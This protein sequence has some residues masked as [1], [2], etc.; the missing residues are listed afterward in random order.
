MGSQYEAAST[1]PCVPARGLAGPAHLSGMLSGTSEFLKK[2][3]LPVGV[4]K[5]EVSKTGNKPRAGTHVRYTRNTETWEVH[6]QHRD[7]FSAASPN[8][9]LLPVLRPHIP[10]PDVR[11]SEFPAARER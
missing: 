2:P 1:P 10:I 7:R 11:A 4:R 3:E 8:L 6:T 9:T 5:R